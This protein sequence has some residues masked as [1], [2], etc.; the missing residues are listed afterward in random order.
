MLKEIINELKQVIKETELNVSHQVIFEQAV[1]LYIS[2]NINKSMKEQKSNMN[3]TYNLNKIDIPAS[4]KQLKALKNIGYEGNMN[5]SKK[6][7]WAIINKAKGG[8]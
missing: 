3:K 8:N 6:E 2:D 1:D 5:L 7:A 4:D